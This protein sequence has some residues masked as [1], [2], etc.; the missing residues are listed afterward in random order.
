MKKLGIFIRKIT[1]PPVF[2]LVLLFSVCIKNLNDVEVILHSIVGI[3]FIAFFPVLAYPLQKHIPAF[4]DKGRDGQRT[5]AIIFSFV[6][7]SI[8]T[9]L[10][11]SLG[12]PR[13]IKFIYLNYLFCG[14]SILI[15]DK[16]FKIKVIGHSCGV[17]GP[18]I[19]M[20]YFRFYITAIICALF[21][22]P[23]FISSVYTKRHTPLQ[24]IGGA[25]IALTMLII[26][27]F[28]GV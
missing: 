15:F 11:F 19:T 28:L 13:I 25:L 1:I 5:L 23:V 17:I 14:F 7:Y 12:A 22:I 6:G 18:M 26:V 21:A 9:I 20:V 24:L 8:G 27:H 10:A 3:V 2:A 16:V 4:K